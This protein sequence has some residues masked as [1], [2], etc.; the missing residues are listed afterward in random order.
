MHKLCYRADLQTLTDEDE[1]IIAINKRITVLDVRHGIPQA[2]SSMI[3]GLIVK[4]T[5]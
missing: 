2:W 4:E 3:A 1:G 5:S